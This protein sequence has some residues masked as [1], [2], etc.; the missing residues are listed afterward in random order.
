MYSDLI[1]I[2]KNFQSSINLELDLTN[3]KKIEEYIPTTDICDVIKKYIKS[4]LGISK[5]KATTIIGPY[6]KGKSFVLLV[7]TYIFGRKK[8]TKTWTNLSN[9]I[10][11]VDSELY[12]LMNRIKNDDIFLLPVII[13]S[14][15]DNITQ[16]FQ[17]GLNDALK[18]EGMDSIIPNSAYEVCISLLDKWSNKENVKEEIIEKCAEVND[19]NISKLRRGLESYSPTAYKQ[20]EKLY[21]CVNIGLEFNPLVNND[22]VKTYSTVASGLSAF[23]CKGMFVIFDEFSKF[24]ESNSGNLMHDLKIIQDFAELASRSG[25]DSQIHLCCVAHK[26]LVLYENNKNYSEGLF[27]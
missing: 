14:N 16:A 5:D 4:V 15:Y 19:L 9:K 12:E 2:N 25:K 23:N 10:K 24:I 22:I 18:R 7:L 27:P 8:E 20:F 11:K 3:E 1:T 6:G 26:S 17:V 21:N 13:N